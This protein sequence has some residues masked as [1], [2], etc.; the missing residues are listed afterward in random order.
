MSSDSAE[1]QTDV[2]IPA[3]FI[4]FTDYLAIHDLVDLNIKPTRV[5]LDAQGEVIS[6]SLKHTLTHAPN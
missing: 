3:V 5:L 2:K 6:L 4:S 1:H